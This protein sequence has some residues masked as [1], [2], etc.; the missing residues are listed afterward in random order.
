MPSKKLKEHLDKFDVPYLTIKHS[1]AFSAQKVAAAAHVP[2]KN[3]IKTVMVMINGQMA[4]AVLPASYRVDFD[5]LKDVTGE[6]NVRLAS[7]TEFKDMFADCE[8]GAMPPFGNLYN[9]EVFVAKSVT[10]NE[11]IAFNAGNF[12]EIIQMSYS[13]FYRLV[14]PKISKFAVH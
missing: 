10:E 8:P 4:M 3:M 12:A 1:Q 13:D 11:E 5:M 9:L 14:H 7:E 6:G 2:G